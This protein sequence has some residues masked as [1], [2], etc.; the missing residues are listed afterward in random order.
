MVFAKHHKSLVI[1][2][3]Q[4]HCMGLRWQNREEVPNDEMV[5]H[6]GKVAR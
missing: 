5:L 1:W 4:A 3:I 2:L 6:D